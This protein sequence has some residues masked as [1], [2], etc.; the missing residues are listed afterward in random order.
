MNGADSNGAG[1]GVLSEKAIMSDNKGVAPISHFTTDE[2]TAPNQFIPVINDLEV[3]H[4]KDLS[5]AAIL[6]GTAAIPLTNFE[7]K[8]ALINVYVSIWHLGFVEVD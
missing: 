3:M 6:K 2:E 4:E 1:R 5:F 8:A 7:R